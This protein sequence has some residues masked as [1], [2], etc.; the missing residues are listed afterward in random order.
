MFPGFKKFII[1]L[2][3]EKE[4]K[5]A[6][7]KYKT[8]EPALMSK[9][10]VLGVKY[11][12]CRILED[13][14]WWGFSHSVVSDSWDR[15]DCSPPACSVHGISQVRILEWVAISF[16]R[17]SS[18]PRDQTCI[19]CI[20]SGLLNHNLLRYHWATREAHW[21]RGRPLIDWVCLHDILKNM[22]IKNKWESEK[23]LELW[24][25]TRSDDMGPV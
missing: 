23:S 12:C 13:R 24:G 15:I 25:M 11:A 14:W 21:R 19:S 10:S 17:G 6:S 7:I 9:K 22:E 5:C 3:K 20:T 16:S 1:Y 8:R 4:G 2:E 18:R